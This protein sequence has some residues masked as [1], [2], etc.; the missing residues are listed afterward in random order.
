[1]PAFS[2]MVRKPEDGDPAVADRI[3]QAASAY[4]LSDRD[5]SFAGDGAQQKVSEYRRLLAERNQGN[6]AG[7]A[8]ETE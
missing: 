1:M 8:T 5:L 4:T 6:G 7:D 3:R 2:M